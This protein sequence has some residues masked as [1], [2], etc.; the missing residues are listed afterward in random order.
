ML[1]RIVECLVLSVVGM[2][3]VIVS[4]AVLAA[5]IAFFRYADE[6]A[7]QW[8]IRRYRIRVEKQRVDPDLND[9]Q[10]AILTAAAAMTFKRPVMVRRIRFSGR[11]DTPSW[12]VTGRLNIMA[13]HLIQKRNPS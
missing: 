1:E 2:G 12:A 4:L 3:V 5:I 10:I 7:N 8:R 11:A 13:S 9:E 6:A